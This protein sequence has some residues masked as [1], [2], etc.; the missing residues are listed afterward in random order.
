MRSVRRET[1]GGGLAKRKM[2]PTNLLFAATHAVMQLQLS[3]GVESCG[4][5]RLQNDTAVNSIR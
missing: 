3:P 4:C 2:F 1:R 5:I